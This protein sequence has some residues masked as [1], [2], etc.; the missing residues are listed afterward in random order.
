MISG[1]VTFELARITPK[2]MERVSDLM[3]LW[4]RCSWLS[5]TSFQILNGTKHYLGY[6]LLTLKSLWKHW[7]VV[8]P[9]YLLFGRSV[10]GPLALLK[11][12]WLHKTDL[13]TAKQNVVEF[14]LKTCEQLRSAAENANEIAAQQCA[15]AKSW[16]VKS[17]TP[18]HGHRLRTPATDTTNGQAQRFY[19]KFAT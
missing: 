10:A 17:Q 12:A 18:L 15:N 3:A 1:L 8:R 11:S 19:N 14:M 5:E 16:Y 9:F 7:A 13:G 4:K 2:P 6:Y